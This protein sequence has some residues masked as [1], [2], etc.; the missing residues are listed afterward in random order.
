[1][2][3]RNLPTNQPSN[4]T[5]NDNCFICSNIVQSYTSYETALHF[6]NEE[7]EAQNT[8]QCHRLSK[9]KTRTEARSD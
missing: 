7:I 5:K 2:S 4:K 6:R 3:P 1:M 9:A 8:V